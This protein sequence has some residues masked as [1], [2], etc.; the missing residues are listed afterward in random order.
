MVDLGF[1]GRISSK[2]S[3]EKKVEPVVGIEPTTD[4][5]Q[6]HGT[7]SKTAYHKEFL[8]IPF[9]SYS[10]IYAVVCQVCQVLTPDLSESPEVFGRVV[11][12]VV[13]F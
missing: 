2:T 6:I 8:N 9:R 7:S 10:L 11:S 4:G 3:S 12:T 13:G 1:S 5:L